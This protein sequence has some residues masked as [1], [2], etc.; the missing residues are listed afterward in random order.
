MCQRRNTSGL[1]HWCW[2]NHDAIVVMKRCYQPN[3]GTCALQ[4]ISQYTTKWMQGNASEHAACIHDML[5]LATP[6]EYKVPLMHAAHGSHT[7]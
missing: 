2:T 5:R 4:T 1:N 3:T 6:P 7:P